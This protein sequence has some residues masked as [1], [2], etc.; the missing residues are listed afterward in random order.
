M[1]KDGTLSVP[2]VPVVPYITGDGV[3]AEVTPSMQAVVNA[4]VQKAYGG[5]RRIEWKE[6][7]AG[8]RAFNETGSWL[9]DETM[10]AFQEYLIGIKGPLTTPVGGGIRS[11]NVALRQTLDL[12]V[13]LR[14]VRWYQGVHSPVKA[15][16]K[17]NM[18]V[19]RENTEDIY[20]GIEWEAGTPEAEKFYQFLKNEM[21][22]TKVRFPE[23]SSFGVKPVSREGTERL[24][25]A[26]CQ[27]ALNHHL[28][29]VTLVHKGN[30]MKFTEGGFKKW[31][32]GAG[33]T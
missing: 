30:I 7:L 9:P 12:Y 5:K 3:G 22:V 14:P 10:K 13:C 2:D 27:Y 23:T 20:A 21:G 32:Y 1:Q 31:G 29:S 19:F 4:A 24:V 26:A 25:R 28:P 33:A 17:V 18:C 11:L 15:P 16:E 8:E 6:V